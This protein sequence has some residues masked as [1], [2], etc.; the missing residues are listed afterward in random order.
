[1]PKSTALVIEITQ[2]ENAMALILCS[3]PNS[4]ILRGK[5]NDQKMPENLTIGIP[6]QML[7]LRPDVRAAQRNLEIAHY[8]TRGAWLN[9]FPTLSIVG[10]VSLVNPVTGEWSPMSALANLGAG[11]V[12]PILNAGKNRATLKAAQSQQRE[13]ML[14]FNQIILQ[15]GNE[16]NNALSDYHSCDQKAVFYTAQVRHLDKAREDTEYLMKN[17][18]DKTYLDV[19]IAYTSFFDAKLNL[20]ANQAKRM[21]AVVSLYSA[22][23]GGAEY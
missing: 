16:V 9:F 22:L 10:S 15:S 8:T 18:L 19:L 1:M 14:N 2:S 3:T 12:A 23:G 6:V 4:E 20:I 21:Q 13:A 5:L 7:T 11:L 17:S